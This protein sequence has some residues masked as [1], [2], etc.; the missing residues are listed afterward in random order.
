MG[1]NFVILLINTKDM[2]KTICCPVPTAI[3]SVVTT[4]NPCRS[5]VGQIQK[6]VFWRKGNSIGT[7]G[8]ATGGT[9]VSTTW[10]ALLA[11][12]DDTKAVVTPFLGN[13]EL[14][15]SEPREFGGGNET[16]D[17]I[18]IKKG[19]Q[20]VPFSADMY[21]EDQD[22]I[23]ALK[24]LECES[25][26]VIFINESNQFIYSDTSTFS[27]FPVS[28]GSMYVSDKGIGGYSDPDVNGIQFMLAPNWSNTLEISEA[29]TFALDM[30][31]S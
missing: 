23:T 2:G 9:G 3:E 26:E 28:I 21:M 19:G 15:K 17:G 24:Q 16:R 22:V 20:S 13:P 14:P 6:M 27:G 29:T 1:S 7:V 4:L 30:V 25:L 12:V 5:D 10:T 8:T 31:N 18:T 11:A